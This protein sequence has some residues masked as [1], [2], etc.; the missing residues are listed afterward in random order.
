VD[1]VLALL[2]LF[3][4]SLSLLTTSVTRTLSISRQARTLTK[5]REAKLHDMGF[6]FDG[7]QAQ[8]VRDEYEAA[9]LNGDKQ[10]EAVRDDPTKPKLTGKRG[11]DGDRGGLSS[12]DI[13]GQM[14]R[15]VA[16]GTRVEVLYTVN[17]E[18]TWVAGTVA[19]IS[20]LDVALAPEASSSA[21]RG[22]SVSRSFS[23]EGAIIMYVRAP[24][25]RQ[26]Y[27][28]MCVCARIHACTCTCIR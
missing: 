26:M 20:R 28:R 3:R 23:S 7:K 12:A 22:A 9:R 15:T 5:E 2:P 19:E 17:G 1:S 13:A 8:A 14:Q 25:H 24:S 10:D 16:V 4:L 27:T 6:I 21:S 18:D 11:R